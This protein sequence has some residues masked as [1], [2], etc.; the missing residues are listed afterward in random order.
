MLWNLEG[1]ST[2]T[3]ILLHII[4]R[5]VIYSAFPEVVTTRTQLSKQFPNVMELE[6]PLPWSLWI[7]SVLPSMQGS[8]KQVR[9]LIL[10]WD[11][12]VVH[13]EH[14]TARTRSVYTQLLLYQIH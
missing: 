6:D 13:I 10:R 11:I 2:F 9:S 8:N 1:L 5:H 4:R 14:A 12:P 3:I 7:I